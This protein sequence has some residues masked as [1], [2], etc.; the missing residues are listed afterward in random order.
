M[1]ETIIPIEW[2]REALRL[3]IQSVIELEVSY[4]LE[5]SPH[6]RS[7]NRRAYRNGY[8]SRQ[9][10][11]RVGDI[12]LYIPK[13]RTGSFYPAL[14]DLIEQAETDLL[15]LVDAAFRDGY[16]SLN[17]VATTLR[18][19]GIESPESHHLAGIADLLHD[20]V[21]RSRVKLEWQVA[22]SRPIAALATQYH[23][24]DPSSEQTIPLALL[25][26]LV[27]DTAADGGIELLWRV[28]QALLRERDAIAA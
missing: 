26:N 17:E 19:L 16:V 20:L 6:E 3:L 22:S 27:T 14:L 11:S 4:W 1:T 5:A 10:R 18:K 21:E 2:Q 15:Q 13:L 28:R 12:Q 25:G 23:D 9:W 8:R 24:F 7:Q